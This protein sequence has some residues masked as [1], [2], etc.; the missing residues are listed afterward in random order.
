MIDGMTQT[1]IK[2]DREVRDHLAAL[3]RRDGLTMGEL[4]ERLVAERA[5]LDRFE[6]LR[7]AFAGTSADDLADLHTDG[8]SWEHAMAADLDRSR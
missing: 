2:V 1:T 3:A 8:E 6:Q 4:L 7:A 5:R